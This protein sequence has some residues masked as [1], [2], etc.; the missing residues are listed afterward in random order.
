MSKFSA[1][2]REQLETCDPRIQRVF[3]E[4]IKYFDCKIIEGHRGEALQ[5]MYY[6]QHKS[7]KHWPDG[8]HNSIPSKAV[9]VMPYPINWLDSSRMCYFAGYVMAIG[10]LMGIKIRWGKDW[11]GD[12]DLSDQKF[13]DGPHYELVD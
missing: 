1:F 13:C 7:E 12:T 2:S 3:N 4:V 10:I 8:E 9:D 5:N 11:D 6:A